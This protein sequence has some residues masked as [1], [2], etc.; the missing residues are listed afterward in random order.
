M[1]GGKALAPA[2][3]VEPFRGQTGGGG[4]PKQPQNMIPGGNIQIILESSEMMNK[5]SGR[6]SA[7]NERIRFKGQENQE[8]QRYPTQNVRAAC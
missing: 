6:L 7:S 8:N 2:V 5:Q 1:R 3:L 4:D